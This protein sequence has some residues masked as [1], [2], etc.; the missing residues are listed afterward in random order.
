MTYRFTEG[1][2]TAKALVNDYLKWDIPTR[3]MAFRSHWGLDDSRLPTPEHFHMYEPPAIDHWPMLITVQFGTSRIERIDYFDGINPVFRCTYNMRTYLWV[4]QDTPEEAT[5]TRDRLTAVLRSA[6]LD[7]P[8]FHRFTDNAERGIY[9]VLLDEN[10]LREEYSD[11]TY[12][13]GNRVVSGAYLGY[14]LM[15]DEA[16]MRT[17]ASQNL[18]EIV[19]S[20]DAGGA[21]LA[22][23]SKNVFTQH[24]DG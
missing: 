23:I 11:V 8:S 10:T 4:K 2:A 18:E 9:G 7:T 24:V 13:K 14:S 20:Y 21:P 22:D 15:L 19:V 6:F 1:A 5:E 3:I 17:P 12:V 16:V